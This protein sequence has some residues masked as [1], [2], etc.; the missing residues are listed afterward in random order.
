[1]ARLVTFLVA[2][3]RTVRVE[4]FGE[5]VPQ[6]VNRFQDLVVIGVEFEFQ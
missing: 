6:L 3:I 4:D 5:L 1:M 2:V